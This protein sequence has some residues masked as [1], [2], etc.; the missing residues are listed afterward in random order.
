[1]IEPTIPG[2]GRLRLQYLVT[3]VNGALAL[4][5]VLKDGLSKCITSLQDRLEIDM[6]TADTH[7]RQS[8]IDKQLNLKATRVQPGDEAAKKADFF[9][10]LGAVSVVALRQGVNDAK[11]QK[12]AALGI[13]VMSQEGVSVETLVSADIVLPDIIAALDLLDK[14][15]RIVASL[16]K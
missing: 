4:D 14:P 11:M 8:T 7:G 9:Q 2:R 10:N 16:R 13:C 6:L 3:D 12:A 15:V 1:M 5:G